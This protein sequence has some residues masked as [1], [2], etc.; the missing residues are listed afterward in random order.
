[1][2]P[3]V[4]F[5]KVNVRPLTDLSDYPT[6]MTLRGTDGGIH[7]A[8]TT[9]GKWVFDANCAHAL[10]LCRDSLNYCCSG[11]FCEGEFYGVF[12]V[13]R[14]SETK[15]KKQKNLKLPKLKRNYT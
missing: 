15:N 13:V 4:F 1:M 2:A 7:H 10:P 14:F 6:A 9:V 3:T 5:N 8:I 12:H 11:S